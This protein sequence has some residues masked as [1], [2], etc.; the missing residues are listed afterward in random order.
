MDGNKKAVRK[1]VVMAMKKFF[2]EWAFLF[3]LPGL[4]GFILFYIFPFF[5]SV[6]F[7]FLDRPVNGSFVGFKNYIDL[8][9][10]NS[11]LT[12][13]KNTAIFIGLCVPLNMLLSLTVASLINRMKKYKDTFAL[14]FLIP[15]V[16]PSG[17]MVFFWRILF[18]NGDWLQNKYSLFVIVIIFLWKNLGY[19]MVLFL[20]G[21]NNIPKEYYEAARVDGSNSWQ[22]FQNITLV[23]LLPTTVLTLIMSVINSFKVFREV[24][25]IM[26]TY[27]HENVYMLQHFMNNMFFSLNYPRLTTATSILTLIIAVFAWL[28][29]RLERRIHV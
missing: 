2:S 27:P 18:A 3:I 16:I 1:G 15:L 10:N 20:A 14:L 9:H 26:G 17:A 29:F 21:L 23:C 22:S 25:L 24:Y 7:S 13:L 12:G 11:Y 19:N 4:A 28:L 8:L 6:G 5:V